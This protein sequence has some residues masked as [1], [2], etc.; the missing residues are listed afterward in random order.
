MRILAVISLGE[1]IATGTGV[2]IAFAVVIWIIS[3]IVDKTTKDKTRK[4]GD[5]S[6]NPQTAIK[7]YSD[8]V[9]ENVFEI[10]INSKHREMGFENEEWYS[11]LK[12][13]VQGAPSW[14]A[15]G[16]G[17]LSKI[18]CCY[19]FVLNH[20][21]GSGFDV[22]IKAVKYHKG[23]QDLVLQLNESEYSSR[24]VYYEGIELIEIRNPQWVG[25]PPKS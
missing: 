7:Y 12:I 24:F 20:S 11:V 17:D 22:H 18:R 4:S 10:L 19:A 21:F 6:H 1:I 14:T 16:N 25:W 8:D 2:I 3:V 23:G 9:L 13:A 15:D 5:Y